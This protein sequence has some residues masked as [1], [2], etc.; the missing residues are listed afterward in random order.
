MNPKSKRI[1]AALLA[2]LLLAGLLS[3]HAQAEELVI[4]DTGDAGAVLE[5]ALP[6]AA[7]QIDALD[8]ALTANAP[9]EDEA[10]EEEEAGPIELLISKSATKKVTLGL[11]YQI[12]VSGKTIKTCK[13]SNKKV[14]TVTGNGLVQT[15][16]AGTAK[17]TV[18]PTKGG[19]L[20]LTL[21]VLDPRTPTAVAIVEGASATVSAGDTL[22][23][24]A[25]VSPD[26]AP[27]T[28]N[29][30]SSSEKVATVTK[31]GLVTAL[32]KGTATITATTGNKLS[33]K[34]KLTVRKAPMKPCVIAHAMGGISGAA[35][36]NSLD[37]FKH[38][39][40]KGHRLFEVDLHFTSDG[41]LV[42]WHSW[43]YQFCASH[44]PGY[45]PSHR[46]FMGS[47]I[48]DKYTPLD[49]KKLLKLMDRYPDIRIVLD[50]KYGKL[51]TAKREFKLIL[52]TAKSL[53][54]TKVLDR[55]IVELYSED[56]YNVVRKIHAFPE[57][58]LALYKLFPGQPGEEEF[59][60]VAEACQRKGIPTIVMDATWW[61]P[62]F[63]DIAAECG[64]KLALYTVNDPDQA[65]AFFDAGVIALFT[66]DL[67]PV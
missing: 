1:I 40:D 64:I 36:T 60:A 12:V 42:L 8:A 50:G 51:D 47:K 67:P 66:D 19:K 14:A 46:E 11:S 52:S 56:M 34:L 27:Q 61:N 30:K 32:K 41:K 39:Y 4:E 7:L 44:T 10:D 37:A 49:L 23:L 2:W 5:L 20:T 22:Q 6:D 58:M 62:A 18:T 3:A 38:N 28:V 17:I 33:A 9:E 43:D 48:Y 15:K 25:V 24:T 53:K 31:D 54:L 29:W 26:T 45:K 57:Y 16:K 63:V 13:S 21:K 35:Y 59:R 65:Q 55:M